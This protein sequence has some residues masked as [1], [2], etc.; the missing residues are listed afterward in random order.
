ME[1]PED[2][3]KAKAELSDIKDKLA[4]EKENLDKIK[5]KLR[6]LES[7]KRKK[8]ALLLNYLSIT[9]AIVVGILTTLIQSDDFFKPLDKKIVTIC[10][11][12]QTF[13]R[14]K[15][16]EKTCEDLS[17]KLSSTLIFTKDSLN[18][19][20][21]DKIKFIQLNKRIADLDTSLKKLELI[22]LDNPEKALSIPLLKQQVSNQQAQNEKDFKNLEN[23][24]ARVY[25]INKWIIGLVFGMLVSIIILN[26][27]N[28]ISKNKKES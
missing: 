7:K 19:N 24:I 20:D 6:D 13:I 27:S 3:N 11:T 23:E 8:V 17:V 22:I 14:I 10:D 16:L 18:K 25:D 4:E 28:L 15:K 1:N 2:K 21:L 9:I 5:D 26:I 12:T